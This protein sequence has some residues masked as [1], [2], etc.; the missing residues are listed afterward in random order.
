MKRVVII[1]L[2]LAL[3]L[4]IYPAFPAPHVFTAFPRPDNVVVELDDILGRNITVPFWA[5]DS[6][7]GEWKQVNLTCHVILHSNNRSEYFVVND[8]SSLGIENVTSP[9]LL[10]VNN[11]YFLGPKASLMDADD[12]GATVK[13]SL[14]LYSGLSAT[15]EAYTAARMVASATFAIEPNDTIAPHLWD[16]SFDGVDD[17][18]E[19]PG[20]SSLDITGDLTLEMWISPRDRGDYALFD[21]KVT[22]AWITVTY[23][24]SLLDTGEV[25]FIE[26]DGTD[27]Y[28][29]TSTTTYTAGGWNHIVVVRSSDTIKFAINGIIESKTRTVITPYSHTQPL[30]IGKERVDRYFLDGQTAS[31]RIYSRALGDEEIQKL[32]E[33]AKQ[34]VPLG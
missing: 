23:Y 25:R 4:S 30:W 19:V 21:K 11:T 9:Y 16:W 34:I 22:G 15:G 3:A 6:T 5:Q 1:W 33:L 27:F 7:T 13:G 24:L 26:G 17:Y 31:D 32:Y 28:V 8:L 14:Y 12:L 18:V 20:D 10:K 29:Y 2:A